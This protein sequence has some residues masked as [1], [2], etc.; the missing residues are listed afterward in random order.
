MLCLLCSYS[1]LLFGDTSSP[2]LDLIHNRGTLIVGVKTD[3]EPWGYY[4]SEGDII[5]MEPDLAQDIADRL[6]VS[7]T[8][9]PVTSSNR[10]SKLEA[11]AVDLLIATMSDTSK[12]RLQ[13]GIIE[14]SYYSSGATVLVP[15][16]GIRLDSWAGLYGRSICLT[17][18]AYFNRDLKERFLLKAKEFEGTRDN[19]AALRFG[20]CAGWIYDDSAIA[21]LLQ[22]EQWQG[23]EAPL[24][25]IMINPWAMA[26][27]T[28]EK[29]TAFGHLI[30]DAIIDWHR[31]GKLLTLEKKWNI[32]QSQFLV[33]QNER[34]SQKNSNGEYVC[35]RLNK[36]PQPAD[37]SPT[38]NSSSNT[39]FTPNCL[40][41]RSISATTALRTDF[42][43]SLGINFPPVYDQY[44]RSTLIKGIALTLLISLLAIVGSLTFGIVTGIGLYRL[45]KLWAWP[46]HRINDMFRMTPPLLNLYIIFFGLG[47]LA[48]LHYGIQFNA[49][50]V[51]LIVLSSYAGASNAA[52]LCQA[53]QE[54]KSHHP[55]YNFRSLFASAFQHAYEGINANSVNIVKA[56]GLASVI[57]VPELI[58]S[59]NSIIA[60]YGNKAEMMTFLLLFYFFIVYFFI[61]LLNQLQHWVSHKHG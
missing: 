40:S 6:D 5:G 1:A 42:L 45:P 53:L 14:P 28:S 46:A 38:S 41:H 24:N 51:A 26:V 34:W 7:L 16:D 23:F 50:A 35:Q 10:I 12:R 52:L 2:R 19:L 3:Y 4:S 31:T 49:I 17:K 30:S 60:D 54:A 57:A 29:G 15:K 55:D 27:K 13:T 18:N 59:T 9:V 8:L 61:F 20:T 44:S 39:L 47:G 58:S 43:S 56:A 32:R 21:K 48:G 37:T 11:G 25:T 33:E 36:E 22:E